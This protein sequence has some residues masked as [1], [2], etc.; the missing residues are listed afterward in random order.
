[1]NE[2]MNKSLK[3]QNYNIVNI[4]KEIYY[5]DHLYNLLLLKCLDKLEI[6]RQSSIIKD[7]IAHFLSTS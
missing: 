2:I 7:T 5:V 4:D 6:L 3:M 1:M